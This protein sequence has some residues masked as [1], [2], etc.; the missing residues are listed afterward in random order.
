M[1]ILLYLLPT[2]LYALAWRV[3][4]PLAGAGSTERLPRGKSAPT[5]PPFFR[6]LVLVAVFV[7]GVSLFLPISGAEP[8]FGFAQFLSAAMWLAVGML[9]LESSVLQLGALWVLVLPAAAAVAWMP[10]VFAGA[11][12]TPPEAPLFVP[13][14]V[15][16]VMAYSFM[17]L[18]ALQSV[19]MAIAERALLKPPP[20]GSIR[21]NPGGPGSTATSAVPGPAGRA[22]WGAWIETLPPLMALERLLFHLITAGFVFLSLTVLTGIVFSEAAFGR[23]FSLDHK[24]VFTLLSW[25]LFATLLVGRRLHGWRG[26]TALRLTLGGFTLLML[27]YAGSRF[28]LE[29][30]LGRAG[31]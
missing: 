30:F 11:R 12:L 1:K 2:L 5:T 7:H 26:R 10:G 20:M 19:L 17:T 31:V 15:L 6:W 23:P 24:T 25:S 13:H 8:R 18:A 4:W 22:G 28:V 14:L 27:A 3:A 21:I 9:W 29:V 16:G